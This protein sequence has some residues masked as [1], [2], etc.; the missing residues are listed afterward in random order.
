M[1]RQQHKEHE[2]V[3]KDIQMI[4]VT[5]QEP[6]I[7]TSKKCTNLFIKCVGEDGSELKSFKLEATAG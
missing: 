1:T 5:F 3:R 6:D 4:T 7:G 2:R